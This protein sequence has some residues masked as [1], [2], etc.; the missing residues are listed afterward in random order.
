ML[1]K[2]LCRIPALFLVLGN[3]DKFPGR[4]YLP[5]LREDFNVGMPDGWSR[6]VQ[7]LKLSNCCIILRRY[8]CS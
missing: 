2:E 1:T 3:A 4:A 5:A 6:L 8:G 7:L